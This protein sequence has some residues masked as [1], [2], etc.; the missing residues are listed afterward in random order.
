M[1]THFFILAL[2]VTACGWSQGTTNEQMQ[3][4]VSGNDAFAFRLYKNLATTDGNLLISPF[5]ISMALTMVSAGSAGDTLGEMQK[6]LGFGPNEQDYHAAFAALLPQIGQVARKSGVSLVVRNSLWLR[7]GTQL[8]P[9][10]QAIV[11]NNY[12]AKLTTVDFSSRE[13]VASINAWAREATVGHVSRVVEEK[14]VSQDTKL[15]LINTIF[16]K[17]TWQF[18][19]PRDNTREDSFFV[20]S[21]RRITVPMMSQKAVLRYGLYPAVSILELPYTRGG[22]SLFI[23]LPTQRSG[24]KQFENTLTVKQAE[25][26]LAGLT[27][28]EVQVYLPKFTFEGTIPLRDPLSAMGMSKPFQRGANFQRIGP[29]NTAH[30]TAV[31]HR[32]GIELDEDGTTAWA[33][34]AVH[35]EEGIPPPPPM[36]RA[37]HPFLFILIEKSSGSIL[38]MGRVVNPASKHS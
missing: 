28:T 35:M 37:D 13:T 24:L 26:L 14:D 31:S 23:F 30:I 29:D 32:A 20:T 5:S 17:G 19:F 36:F 34:T 33:S 1:K 22:F 10:F 3:T 25:A 12:R 18:R 8:E 15:L 38:F 21:D 2:L 6:V 9:S 27:P 16:F 7:Q 11:T 4:L